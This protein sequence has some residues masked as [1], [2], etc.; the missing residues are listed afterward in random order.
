MI[1][2]NDTLMSQTKNSSAVSVCVFYFR[3]FYKKRRFLIPVEIFQSKKTKN[4]TL[5]KAIFYSKGLKL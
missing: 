3:E 5:A 2:N 1:V 4:L